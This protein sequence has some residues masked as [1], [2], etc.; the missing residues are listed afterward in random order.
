MKGYSLKT[1]N[2]ASTW[3]TSIFFLLLVSFLGFIEFFQDVHY[4]K[5]TIDLTK[6]PVDQRFLENIDALSFKNR[7]GEFSV[8]KEKD[9]WYLQKPRVVPAKEKTIKQIINTLANIKI[10]TIHKHEPINFQSFSL[11]RP[12]MDINLIS[13]DQ[14]KINVK[15][16]LINP[17]DNTSFLTVSGHNRIYQTKLFENKL[18]A[19]ELSDFIESEIFSMELAKIKEFKL[20]HNKNSQP[21]NH[22][23]QNQGSWMAKKYKV[24]NN[25]R[26]AKAIEDILK[27]KTHMIIDKQ[28]EKLKNFI[29]NYLK[30]PLYRIK[31]VLNNGKTVDYKV[32]HLIRS[33]SDLKLENKQ[34][35]IMTASDRPYPYIIS[36]NFLNRFS[37]RY[38]DIR[39]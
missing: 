32:T 27:T 13:K 15:I 2:L 16:G 34:F 17:I 6:S 4:Q 22:F 1:R 24:V 3:L 26:V 5:A 23:S 7:L 36:K 28:D 33:I 29:N 35:F 20:Y 31:V 39:N 11:D 37:I 38:S 25:T 14:E 9:G 10:I 18:A 8:K 12:V 21:Y 30:A 19:L